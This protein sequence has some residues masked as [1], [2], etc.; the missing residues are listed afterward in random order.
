[1]APP[2]P[3][4][5]AARV[6]YKVF[7][8]IDAGLG[9]RQLPAQP[10]FGEGGVGFAPAL[11]RFK[12]RTFGRRARLPPRGQLRGVEAL[13]AQQCP[14]LAD[15]GTAVR[16]GQDATLSR[17]ENCR[18]LAVAATSGFGAG[19]ARAECGACIETVI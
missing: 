10:G 2:A 15:F 19:G 16:G 12:P 4:P 11:L 9:G 18:R 8:D 14:D 13:A 6:R 5:W 17:L 1:M 7:L 3:R